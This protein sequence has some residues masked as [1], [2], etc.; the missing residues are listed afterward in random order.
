MPSG[1][2]MMN[3]GRGS[4]SVV[5]NGFHFRGRHSLWFLLHYSCTLAIRLHVFVHWG[6][7]STNLFFRDTGYRAVPKEA[8]DHGKDDYGEEYKDLPFCPV[9]KEIGEHRGPFDLGLI[10]IG[11]YNPRW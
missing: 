4:P 6:Y 2:A 10:P 1:E 8:E 11:A 9:F 3:L 5:L 7:L